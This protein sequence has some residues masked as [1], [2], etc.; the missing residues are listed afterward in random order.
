VN[1]E[2]RAR[3]AVHDRPLDRKLLSRLLGDRGGLAEALKQRQIGRAEV[4][5]IATK[6]D[7]IRPWNR[8]G[9]RNLRVVSPVKSTMS[10]S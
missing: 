4:T 7:R 1:E 2:P 5:W 3:P 6:V 8:A 9:G 10:S